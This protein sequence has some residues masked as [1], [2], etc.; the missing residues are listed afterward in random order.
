MIPTWILLPVS[1]TM[2]SSVK[3]ISNFSSLKLSG[4]MV[5]RGEDSSILRSWGREGHNLTTII[6]S[7]SPVGQHHGPVHLE[8]VLCS[9]QVC[10]ESYGEQVIGNLFSL[11]SPNEKASCCHVLTFY[12]MEILTLSCASCR[13]RCGT[14]SSGR[15]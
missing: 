2:P 5:H 8:K 9:I 12:S 14:L 10:A 4:D 1:G 11:I 7:S 15:V 13:R 3:I 6:R